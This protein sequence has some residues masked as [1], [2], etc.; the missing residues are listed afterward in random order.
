MSQKLSKWDLETDA[1]YVA[2]LVNVCQ[3]VVENVE[4]CS[5][6]HGMHNNIF[7][8]DRPIIGYDRLH[9]VKFSLH[10]W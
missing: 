8:S 9:L 7:L 1:E 5:L 6:L 2:N 10:L 4:Q 3:Y